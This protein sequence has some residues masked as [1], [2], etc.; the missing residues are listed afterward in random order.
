M[1]GRSWSLL[2]LGLVPLLTGCTDAVAVDESLASTSQEVE[3]SANGIKTQTVC[4]TVHNPGDPVAVPVTGTRFSQY[5]FAAQHPQDRVLLLL[6]G[7]VETREIFDG[8]K[9]GV[10]V[11]GSFARLLAHEGY[12]VVT[13][14][15][16]GYGDSPYAGSAR[17]LNFNGYVEMTHEI[18]TQIHDGTYTIKDGE[19]CG[20]G[21]TVDVGSESVVLGGH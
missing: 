11:D 4:F 3:N 14:D 16:V 2:A 6:H 18:I 13:V 9:A 19:S 12:I 17:A 20:S 21:P 10:D 1:I 7:A 8:G 15:R 5:S